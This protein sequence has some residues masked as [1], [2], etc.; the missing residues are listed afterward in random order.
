MTQDI[1]SSGS[2]INSIVEKKLEN[3]RLEQA[4]DQLQLDDLE[5]K[6]IARLEDRIYANKNN[7]SDTEISKQL[8]VVSEKV[9]RLSE[10]ARDSTNNISDI[11]A[12]LQRIELESNQLS[13][14]FDRDLMSKIDA[15]LREKR[16]KSDQI[17]D[18]FIALFI[19]I[20]GALIGVLVG[21]MLPV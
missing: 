12:R 15:V 11:G 16:G 14:R 20:I 5:R 2:D 4:R 7:S 13:T 19:G 8:L 10:S 9:S 21:I 1:P 3:I 17:R 6:M 18:Y